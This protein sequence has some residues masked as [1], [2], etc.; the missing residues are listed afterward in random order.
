VDLP[1]PFGPDLKV[2]VLAGSS[3]GGSRPHDKPE[4]D[5]P[6]RD[7]A[8]LHLRGRL[9][10]EYVLDFLRDCALSRVWV[11]ASGPRL[12]QIPGRYAFTPLAQ[13]PGAGF[14]TNLRAGANAMQTA[15]DEPV[16]LVFGDHPFNT[17]AVLRAFLTGCSQRLAEGDVFHA[18]ATQSAYRAFAPWF[19]RTSM[20]TRDVRGRASGLTLAIPSRVRHLARLEELYDLRKLERVR[21]YVHLTRCLARWVGRDTPRATADSVVVYLAKELEKAARLGGLPGRIAGRLESWLASQV[22]MARL[23]RYASRV[24]GAERGVRIVPVAQGA[25]AIDVDFA[26]ELQTLERHWDSI[27]AVADRQDAA[28]SSRRPPS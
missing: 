18:L 22:P 8:F 13:P 19:T 14:F 3:P 11:L 9:V 15:P 2:L 6:L 5:A 26:H 23:E 25:I 27:R 17:P 4:P 10:I 7:K 1:L 24:L 16:L 20:H 21:S 12:A 28:L